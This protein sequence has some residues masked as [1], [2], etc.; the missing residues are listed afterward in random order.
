MLG[1][2]HFTVTDSILR[3]DLGPLR[4]PDMPDELER[5]KE[6]FGACSRSPQIR[7]KKMSRNPNNW[8]G[9]EASESNPECIAGRVRSAAISPVTLN[10]NGKPEIASD[11]RCVHS[12]VHVE[13]QSFGRT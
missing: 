5:L 3:G 6:G 7:L 1:R 10:G 4:D 11:G 9:A 8:G 12:G 2:Y 13:G